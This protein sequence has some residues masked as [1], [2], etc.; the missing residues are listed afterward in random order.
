MTPRFRIPVAVAPLKNVE[1]PVEVERSLDSTTNQMQVSRKQK[2]SAA[3]LP[4]KLS[5]SGSLE[6]SPPPRGLWS[7]SLE[8]SSQIGKI[9]FLHDLLE[10]FGSDLS[11]SLQILLLGILIRGER[12][13]A[14]VRCS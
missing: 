7:F 10:T 13:V 9:S 1:V 8:R 5:S 3:R 11:L 2:A 12:H 14:S 4:E 6:T